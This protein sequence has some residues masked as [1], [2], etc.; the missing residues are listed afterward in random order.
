M[1]AHEFERVLIVANPESTGFR[2]EAIQQEFNSLKTAFPRGHEV[3][4]TL[5]DPAANAG[6]LRE[7]LK[8]GDLVI[9]FGGDRTLGQ[10]ASVLA[11]PDFQDRD[12]TLGPVAGGNKNDFAT[13]IG[14][15][16]VSVLDVVRYGRSG[17][18]HL[19]ES[20]ITDTDGNTS[21]ERAINVA[22]L[23]ASA[24][25][26]QSSNNSDYR[27]VAR[28]GGVIRR[29]MSDLRVVSGALSRLEPF[30]IHMD[31]DPDSSRLRY[32]ITFTNSRRVG[33]RA[34]PPTE[35]GDERFYK[36]ELDKKDPWTVGRLIGGLMLGVI[37]KNP[38]KYLSPPQEFS[39]TLGRTAGVMVEF[40][41]DALLDGSNQPILYQ[42]GAHF[43]FRHSQHAVQVKQM[44]PY[45]YPE[46]S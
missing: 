13:S 33:G 5:E 31:D 45:G 18:V 16:Q 44:L 23:G 32:E 41:G 38:D 7:S 15:A 40:D 4:Y 12:I 35:A 22:S 8:D 30:D 26:S 24:D 2:T 42:P 39:F 28:T 27:E 11:E 43:S 6:M 37:P 25:I 14:N 20:E 9:P 29:A 34:K 19:I 1:S 36:V 21:V 17:P 3:R 10:T 46:F